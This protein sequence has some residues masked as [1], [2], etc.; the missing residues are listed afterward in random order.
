VGVDRR[1]R[2]SAARLDGGRRPPPAGPHRIPAGSLGRG[3]DTRAAHRRRLGT[4][5]PSSANPAIAC[6]ALT[7]SPLPARDADR[8]DRGICQLAVASA[9]GGPFTDL[10]T[11]KDEYRAAT[12]FGSVGAFTSRLTVGAAGTRYLRFTVTGKNRASS[13]QVL[14]LDAIT[15]TP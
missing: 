15:L 9:P 5:R 12:T 4:R 3:P 14:N 1:G 7:P 6:R 13:G 10:D 11:R 8:S 2:R